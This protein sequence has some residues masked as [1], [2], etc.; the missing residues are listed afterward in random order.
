MFKK[1]LSILLTMVLILN[2][3]VFMVPCYAA[4]VRHVGPGQTY[5]GTTDAAVQQA[6]NAASAGDT[7]YIHAGTYTFSHMVVLKSGLI[8]K[9]DGINN[10]IIY[11]NADTCNTST[12]ESYFHGSGISN[13]EIY[14]LTFKSSSA[15][16]SEN[17]HGEYRNCMQF[18]NCSYVTVH[19]CSAPKWIYS[20]FFRCHSSSY[21]KMYN[22]Q[23]VTGHAAAAYYSC[24]NSKMYNC[25][26]LVYT[27][28]GVRNYNSTNCEY[29]NNTV[30]CEASSGQAA[31]EMQIDCA[32]ANMHHNIVYDFTKSYVGHYV[33]ENQASGGGAYGTVYFRDNVYWNCSGGVQQTASTGVSMDLVMSNNTVNPSDH[34]VSNWVAQGYGYS[35]TTGT[36]V[37][38]TGVSLNND[39]MTLTAGGSTGSLTAAVAPTNATN[40]SITWSSSNT[41]VA[42]VSN[43]AVT[44][45]A[46]GTATITVTT[47]DGSFTDTCA[48]TVNPGSGD[49]SLYSQT[50]FGAVTSLGTGNT[51]TVTVEFNLTPL[52]SN[53]SG[54]VGYADSSTTIS[55]YSNMGMLV[56]LQST[57]YF[58]VRNGS[59]T[60]ALVNVPFSANN[61]Y[62]FKLIADTSAKTY[63][64]Y[65]TPPSGSETK[66]ADDYAF[67]TT[68]MDDVGKICL[69]QASGYGNYKVSNHTVNTGAQGITLNSQTGFSAVAGL[70]TGNTGTVNIDFTL[71]PLASNS[72]GVVGFA[73]SSTTIDEYGDMGMLIYLQTTGY[74]QVRNGSSTTALVNV[75]FSANNT[76]YFSI[77]ADTSAKTY[78]V[79]VTPQGGTKTLIADNYAFRTTAMDDVGKVCLAQ[80]S[81]Y[82]SYQVSSLVV[83]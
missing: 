61:I 11:G 60:G 44:P 58:E 16:P 34:N 81:G 77:I 8:I 45:V 74:F 80:A 50:G 73:D 27:N 39:T 40:K 25:S 23:V 26:V 52:A 37:P 17:G 78:D 4:T 6:I 10:T 72:S 63:D 71:T 2:C 9:G 43:G 13:V 55:D 62:H 54:V 20:D 28:A 76:Y 59:T 1:K 24:S 53:S 56:Y 70:G 3:M 66:I 41:G 51:G 29:Y 65:V 79:Y 31:F 22:C 47:Q 42:T 57:G 15:G 64:V 49:N 82:G 21:M 83:E 69:A 32:G 35:A 7:I 75:P 12:E 38:V 68:A 33:V 48:V 30:W 67:R 5:N 19:D 46:A 18:R 36:T 14:G